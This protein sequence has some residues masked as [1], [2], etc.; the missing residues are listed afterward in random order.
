M[1]YILNSD[2]VPHDKL[3][4]VLKLEAHGIREF[5]DT[6]CAW[7]DKGNLYQNGKTHRDVYWICAHESYATLFI[8]APTALSMIR[9]W[10]YSFQEV[11]QKVFMKHI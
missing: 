4:P 6:I 7:A 5:T 10:K 3:L 8:Y 1:F 9:R 2:A 11:K